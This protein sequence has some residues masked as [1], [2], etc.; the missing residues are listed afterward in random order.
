[1]ADERLRELERLA[2]SEGGLEAQ[3][4]LLHYR[5]RQGDLAPEWLATAAHLGHKAAR[6]TLGRFVPVATYAT[7]R[8][9]L[10]DDLWPTEL[11]LRA[12]V[13]WLE[14]TATGRLE[15]AALAVLAYVEDPSPARRAALEEQR[16][17][18]RDP[19]STI[20]DMAL[21]PEAGAAQRLL[22]TILPAVRAGR[23]SPDRE[24]VR[25]LREA[26]QPFALRSQGAPPP[27]LLPPDPAAW[28]SFGVAPAA[29]ED[30]F[31]AFRQALKAD[32][33][34]VERAE[35]EAAL[36][37]GALSED[38]V[39]LAALLGSPAA[40][41]VHEPTGQPDLSPPGRASLMAGSLLAALTRVSQ[42]Q[43]RDALMRE[44][45]LRD[46]R[47]RPED[48]TLGEGVTLPPWWRP[49]YVHLALTLSERLAGGSEPDS[50]PA[51]AV[52]AARRLLQDDG[53]EVA[54]LQAASELAVLAQTPDSELRRVSRPLAGALRLIVA[55][56]TRAER[57]TFSVHG[58]LV[59]EAAL[60]PGPLLPDELWE[61]LREAAIE[62]LLRPGDPE[63]RRS[64]DATHR[65]S[66]GDLLLHESFGE[67]E[68]V[69]VRRDRIDVAFADQERTL[70]HRR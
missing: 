35:L 1:M 11:A 5:L 46:L 39:H 33:T 30:L 53:D 40:W 69:G 67:G 32:E 41:R 16:P 63:A 25:D 42:G 70:V 18:A 50:R 29:R 65:Y 6:N 49:L 27:G 57:P 2:Q 3:V 54:L 12:A 60:H 52:A 8:R 55:L 45:L 61:L 19:A 38:R 43:P 4:E 34:E 9:S 13:G 36:E 17:D 44:N 56:L 26:L 24:Q 15:R 68:V 31:H 37:R 48:P 58:Q 20:L 23:G 66:E 22:R 62:W 7:I 51:R 21:L 47:T 10:E 28:E 14:P 59:L 64:Y